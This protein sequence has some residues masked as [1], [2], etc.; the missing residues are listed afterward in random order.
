MIK[1][2]T[3]GCS[4]IVFLVGNYA[5]KIPRVPN[6]FGFWCGFYNGCLHNL[7]ERRMKDWPPNR[8]LCPVVWGDPMGLILVMR[9]AEQPRN[10]SQRQLDR[11][12]RAGRLRGETWTL[13]SADLHVGN[14][15][16][17]GRRLV[18]LDYGS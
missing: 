9:R 11:L 15:G 2:N 8:L 17:L 12:V 10:F 6:H 3:R 13:E 18:L 16:F 4:R 7:R 5:I 14:V 1:R